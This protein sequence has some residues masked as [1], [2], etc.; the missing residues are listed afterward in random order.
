VVVV[1][2]AK[3]R[4]RI[5]VSKQ[6]RQKSDLERFDMKKLI[7]VED[8]EKYQMGI[9]NIFAALQNSDERN[10]T[11][12]AWKSIRGN[13]KTSA[14]ENLG[15]HKLKHNKPWFDDEHSKLT[16]QQKQTKLQ[17]LQNP[18]QINGDNL[19]N[20]RCETRTIFRNKKRKYVKDKINKLGTSNKN[21][22]LI[23]SRMRIIIC[24]EIPTV[25][26]KFYLTFF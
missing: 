11:N 20:L 19:Q 10:D 6:T 1:V 15:Y 24:L 21:K 26:T 16:D 5:S 22:E 4:E 14:K 18:S 17:Q 12:S 25:S 7:D 13:I 8:N 3:L 9:S 23:L 2:V